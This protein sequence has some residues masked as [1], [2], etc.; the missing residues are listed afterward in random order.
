MNKKKF[1]LI[2]LGEIICVVVLLAMVFVTF[3]NVCS[4]YL[5]HASISA[6][7][8]ITT[9]MF[10]VLSLVGAALALDAHTHVGL[11][12]FTDRMKPAVREWF[13]VFEGCTGMIFMGV[14]VYQGFMRV[15][16]QYT[17]GMISA[18][19]S[20]PMWIYG[21]LCLIGFIVMFVEFVKI[22]AGAAVRLAK[23]QP[24]PNG[25][26]KASEEDGK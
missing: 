19:L 6:S 21:T 24:L 22:A 5:L 1:S 11:N 14:L 25:S 10:V 18:G 12:I 13:R 23:H 26:Q 3:I 2:G 7:E 15:L 20:M 9:N 16:Q 17:T 4:R 8:E